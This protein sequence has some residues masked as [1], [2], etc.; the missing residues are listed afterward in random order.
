M[1]PDDPRHQ[2]PDRHR[3]DPAAS[4]DELASALLDGVLTG[5]E[6]AEARRRPD[7]VARAAEMDAARAALRDL[8][9]TDTDARDRAVAAALAAFDADSG[10]SAEDGAQAVVGPRPSDA[11]SGERRPGSGV[12]SD[13]G[14]RRRTAGGGPRRW[15]GAAAAVAAV[16]VGAAGLAALA[17]NESSDQDMA[18]DTSDES[19][20]ESS[21]GGSADD[22]LG[23]DQ[24]EDGAASAPPAE[25][26]D[27]ALDATAREA[28][29]LGTFPSSQAL[30]DH[31]ESL[32]VDA[33]DAEAD[34]DAAEPSPTAPVAPSAEQR[35]S[36][37]DAL[38]H[39]GT[40]CV[41]GLPA[42]L[43]DP[44]ALHLHGTALVDGDAVEVWVIDDSDG[45]RIIAVDPTCTVVV[46][47]PTG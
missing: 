12:V 31:V 14:A 9:A 32:V 19:S 11:A 24:Q 7:V 15:L 35:A 4:R 44:G 43:S 6:A 17:S 13:L 41:A 38:A 36:S 3:A 40:D 28:G 47:R 25:A 27:N 42:P 33:G 20:A 10:P 5:D 34:P 8:P 18:G 30:A 39:L 2:H 22:S 1:T 16:V 21:A 23:A 37:A 26:G 46:D 45:E 29:D